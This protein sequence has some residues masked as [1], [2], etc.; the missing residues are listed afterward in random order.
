[1]SNCYDEYIELFR[2]DS[3][4]FRRSTVPLLGFQTCFENTETVPTSRFKITG[5]PCRMTEF[6][7]LSLSKPSFGLSAKKDT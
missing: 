2:N 7:D 5:L 4:T 3:K 6:E 1:M